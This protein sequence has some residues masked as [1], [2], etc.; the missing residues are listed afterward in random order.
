MINKAFE[1]KIIFEEESLYEKMEEKFQTDQDIKNI[2]NELY[3]KIKNCDYFVK[4]Q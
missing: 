1:Q 4:K 3:I 2:I